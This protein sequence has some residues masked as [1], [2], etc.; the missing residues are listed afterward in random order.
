MKISDQEYLKEKQYKT[1]ENLYTRMYLHQRF[2]TNR[3]NWHQWVFEQISPQEG[4]RILEVGCGPGKLWKENLTR[5]PDGMQLFSSDLSIGMLKSAKIVI[6]KIPESSVTC[7]DVQYIP[8]ISGFFDIVIANHMLYHVPDIDLGLKEISRVLK[9]NGKFYAA[10]NGFNHMQE[11]MELVALIS[12]EYKQKRKQIKRFALENANRIME[13][14]F[15]DVEIEYFD[16]N[17]KV[18][19]TEPLVSYVLSMIDFYEDLQQGKVMEMETL[20]NNEIDY[21]GYFFISKSQGLVKCNQKE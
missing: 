3:I 6:G 16:A 13:L 17:L 10:T 1:A 12:P 7:F 19:E 2:G 4:M 11:L 8:L 20:I 9:P 5:L 14:R 15:D 21:Q 18:T